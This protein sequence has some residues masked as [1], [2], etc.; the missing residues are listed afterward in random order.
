MN[1]EKSVEQL[2][3]ALTGTHIDNGLPR[4][5]DPLANKKM[6]L[7]FLEVSTTVDVGANE[8]QSAK[9]FSKFFPDSD[10][11]WFEPVSESHREL[12]LQPKGADGEVLIAE[13][14][15]LRQ[16]D[17]QTVDD[18]CE[19][20]G[21]GSQEFPRNRHERQRVRRAQER[22]DYMEKSERRHRSAR[23]RDEPAEPASCAFQASV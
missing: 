5:V 1:C 13:T 8:G 4:G 14:T 9:T 6:R 12:H 22:R 15:R 18:F 16:V 19:E 2:S 21:I 17:L 23:G 20:Q 7:P 11:Y 10:I 3:E